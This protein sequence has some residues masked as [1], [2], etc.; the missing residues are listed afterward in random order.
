MNISMQNR[1]ELIERYLDGSLSPEELSEFE[2]QLKTDDNLSKELKFRKILGSSWRKALKYQDTKSEVNEAIRK[3]ISQKR[4]TL[5]RYAIAAI[6]AGIIF[7]TGGIWLNN[8]NNWFPQYA[9]RDSTEE[10]MIVPQMNQQEDKASFGKLDSLI[11]VSPILDKQLSN[12]DSVI[13]CWKPGLP[14]STYIVIRSLKNKE[15]IFKEK[16]VK[17]RQFYYLENNFLPAGE[18]QWYLEGYTGKGNFKIV[19]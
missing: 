17:G 18:Y 11:F 4:T 19:R 9:T 8:K 16:I 2:N 13:F 6:I 10:N 7:I 1:D 3:A 14:N 5:L 15:V 12:S